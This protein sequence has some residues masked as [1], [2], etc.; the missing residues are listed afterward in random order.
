MENDD[1]VEAVAIIGLGQMGVPMAANLRAGGFDVVGFDLSDAA[2]EAAR[3]AGLRTAATP[4]DA[5]D[6]AD[7]LITMLPD[8]AI[9]RDAL[10]GPDGAL[11]GSAPPP[12]VI[13]MSSSAP[14]G[15]VALGADLA[16]RGVALLDAP[17]SGGRRKAVDGTLTIMVGGDDAAIARAMPA[18]EAM[19][20]RI[21]RCGAL[22]TGHAMKALNN[23]VSGAGAVAA[24]EAVLVGRSFGLDPEAMV[25][26]LNVSTGRNN[27][28][29]AK[30]KQFVLSE[31][32]A[33]G[34]GLALM[35]KDIGIA[36]D[37]A[38]AEGMDMPSLPA[39]AT[40]WGE[41]A[42]ALGA[43]A[44]HTEMFRFLAARGQA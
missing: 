14:T 42:E 18:F 5:A 21:F 9:V 43:K 1:K 2:M 16:G 7:A 41:A 44:D 19:G 22:G 29:D 13:D 24:M 34:F 32:F 37:L 15:T 12:L 17:V 20:E 33:S 25:D 11:S 26:I 6:G 10:L 40:L 27:T 35:A 36:A 28:T 23:F 8:G 4:V 3:A 38:L 39:M 31:T 30:M